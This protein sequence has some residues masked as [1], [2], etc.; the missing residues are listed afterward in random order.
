MLVNHFESDHDAQRIQ[1][2][3]KKHAQTSTAA[4]ISGDSLLQYITNARFAGNWRVTLDAFVY[5]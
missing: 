3:V 1:R 5:Y 2:E 4:Q